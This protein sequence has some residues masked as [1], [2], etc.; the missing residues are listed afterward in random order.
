MVMNSK[1]VA[2]L[3]IGIAIV[4]LLQFTISI[5]FVSTFLILAIIPYF[6]KRDLFALYVFEY[7]MLAISLTP[8]VGLFAFLLPVWFAPWATVQSVLMFHL[9]KNN[10]TL[11]RIWRATGAL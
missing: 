4:S 1:R 10:K 9:L 6:R 7:S 8:Y 5:P 11:K 3:G 2:V